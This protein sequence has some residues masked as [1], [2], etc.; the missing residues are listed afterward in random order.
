MKKVC[1]SVLGAIVG[2]AF[3]SCSNHPDMEDDD[4]Q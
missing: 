3:T 1:L 2:L 4:T